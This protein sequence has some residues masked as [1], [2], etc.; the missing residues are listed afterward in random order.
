MSYFS[1]IT[2]FCVF[3]A[4]LIKLPY[5]RI[6]K[7]VMNIAY[8]FTTLFLKH[9]FI[10]WRTWHYNYRYHRYTFTNCLITKYTHHEK[11][12]HELGYSQC[13]WELRK[14]IFWESVSA[15]VYRE[16]IVLHNVNALILFVC[17]NFTVAHINV[18]KAYVCMYNPS[19]RSI[20]MVWFG[21]TGNDII[22]MSAYSHFY[23]HYMT[24]HWWS[25]MLLWNKPG[26]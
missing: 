1:C 5:G 22:F 13:M 25:M 8:S 19:Q 10:F 2:E 24:S 16:H 7:Y 12:L 14:P 9:L 20:F 6:Y 26:M 15:Y 18:L 17:W 21:A 4:Q 23:V 11:S 3:P